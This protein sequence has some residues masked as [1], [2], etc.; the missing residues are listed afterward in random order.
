MAAPSFVYTISCVAKMLGE[1]EDWLDELA[2]M[3]R[4]PEDGCLGIIDDLD[5]PGE[6]LVAVTA[7]TEV[8]IEALKELVAE[9]KRQSAGAGSTG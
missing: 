4:E 3:N 2:S 8:G 5:V 6:Q 7:F 9:V 1:P